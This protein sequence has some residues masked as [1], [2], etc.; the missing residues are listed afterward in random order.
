MATVRVV[1]AAKRAR[2]KVHDTLFAKLYALPLGRFH[3]QNR[4]RLHDTLVQDSNR[5][6]EMARALVGEA[7]P[8]ALTATLLAAALAVLDPLLF[9]LLVLLIAPATLA[10]RLIATPRVRRRID[11]YH[12]SFRRFARGV[13]R[14]LEVMELTRV[15]GAQTTEVERQRA[16]I[17]EVSDS[18][19]RM[20]IL[21]HTVSS[22]QQLVL[23]TAGILILLIGGTLAG[24]DAAAIGDLIA[25]YVGVVMLRNAVLGV[26]AAQAPML[27]GQA[28]MGRIAELLDASDPRPYLGA[29]S[30]DALDSL[31][32]DGVTF[33]HR[34][35]RILLEELR[36][37][38]ARGE[39]IGIVGPNGSGKTSLLALI[40]GLYR[41]E[42]GELFAG[43]TNYDD[44]DI[45]ALRRRLG[46][47]LQRSIFFEGTV[48]E[49][50]TYGSP[51]ATDAEI[52]AAVRAASA[53]DL[54]ARLPHGL[55]SAIG[56]DGVLL[57]GG[58]RQKIAIARALLRRPDV[59]LLDEPTTHLDGAAIERL[60]EDLRSLPQ[61]PAIVMVT[62][63]PRLLPVV[64][65]AYRLESGKLV[66]MRLPQRVH[67][68][69][70]H[71][72]DDEALTPSA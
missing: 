45:A 20:G 25:F 68:W 29:T 48:R 42:H 4:G 61:R 26:V 11:E 41:P 34:E 60:M 35:D 33:A 13:Y 55:E 39:R 59:L 51:E 62:H 43:D 9:G 69:A 5:A 31:E 24:G 17:E 7:L 52:D 36:F 56:D 2:A 46:V 12:L 65:R 58:E 38:L 71:D 30:V 57:S 64:D 22:A 16:L 28:A 66:R 44:W 1:D 47:V 14:A 49:N 8:A 15:Q 63:D 67:A 19:R 32:L 53:E 18:S 23:A 37:G 21:S 50:L 10:L 72:H 27:A 3:H 40:D 54:L 70:V 6:E